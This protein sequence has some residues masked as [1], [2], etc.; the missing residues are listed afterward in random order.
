MLETMIT[1]TR[2]LNKAANHLRSQKELKRLRELAETWMVP[3]NQ[4]EDFIKGKR[5]LLA[6]PAIEEKEY[7]TVNAKLAEELR[8]LDDVLFADIIGTY[9]CRKS[10]DAV[11]GAQVLKRHK[12][13]QKC[14][15]Y[16]LGKAYALA[17]EKRGKSTALHGQ[18]CGVAMTD[19]QV[20]Q[21][22]DDYYA[23]DDEKQ[24]AEKREKA[25]KQFLE[26]KKRE[27]ERKAQKEEQKKKRENT[28]KKKDDKI[29]KE[30]SKNAQL[31]FD[32]L[33]PHEEDEPD[34]RGENDESV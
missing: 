10:S 17:E 19:E 20:F 21:W 22:V 1:N 13:L 5:A 25:K 28:Q 18:Q 31:F 2:E 33:E 4:V 6:D 16:I 3:Y 11:Y 30:A 9:V 24:E 12:T 15:D 26:E 34:E 14:L 7:P 29:R 23:L 27:A 32:F 8:I